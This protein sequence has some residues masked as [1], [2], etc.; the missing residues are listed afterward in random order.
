MP[1]VK[2]GTMHVKRRN[3]LLSRV[4]GYQGNH[5]TKLR[6]ARIAFLK[7]G[8]NAYRSRRL[9]KRDMRKLWSI[10]INAAARQNGT[11]YSRLIHTLQSAHIELDRKILS[12]M[13]AKHPTVFTAI[14]E[15]AK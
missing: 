1:R 2:R 11:T 15:A 5:R 7:A 8:K 9:K 6:S 10:R 3:T 14:V 12:E 4:K 13:A